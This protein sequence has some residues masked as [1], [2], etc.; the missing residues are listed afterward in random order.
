[1]KKI[2]ILALIALSFFGLNFGLSADDG[3]DTSEEDAV[4]TE[5]TAPKKGDGKVSFR[6]QETTDDEES[7]D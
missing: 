1:M 7:Q 2:S 6:D 4:A 5:E 3:K